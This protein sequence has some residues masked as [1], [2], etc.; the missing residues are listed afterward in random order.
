VALGGSDQITVGDLSGTDVTQVNL[1]LA[2]TPGG[3]GDGLADAVIVYG[4][5]GDDV[6]GVVGDGNG[7]AVSGLATQVNIAGAEAAN[8]LLTINALAGDDVVEA[9]GLSAGAIRF[10]ADGGDGDDVLIGGEGNDTLLGGAGDDI[11]I[12][13]PGQDI[14]DG[15]PGDN[16]LF[17]D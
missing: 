14:L 1:D 10:K 6:I 2:A 4:T 15:G 5:K 12:G 3:A 17:Q 16:I 8:D 7:V 9:A 13:G 11:L